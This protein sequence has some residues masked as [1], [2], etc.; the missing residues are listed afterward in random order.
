MN[1]L[2]TVLLGNPFLD[3]PLDTE[4][5][6]R[7][8][9]WWRLVG[10]AVEYGAEQHAAACASPDDAA[11]Q[12][13]DPFA[14]PANASWNKDCLPQKIAFKALFLRQEEDDEESSSLA[15]ALGALADKWPNAANFNARDVATMVNDRSEYATDAAVQQNQILR[16]LLYP[17]APPNLIATPKGVGKR[18]GSLI[19]EP[20]KK[21]DLTMALRKCT[22]A[23]TEGR[24]SPGATA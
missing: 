15:D 2:Y 13:D 22:D 14:S 19:G 18:L 6:T 21:G 8:K 10:S 5:Q 4:C 9:V 11:E 20:V 23:Q 1:A 16:E 12:H 17:N 24:I 3:T 7:F